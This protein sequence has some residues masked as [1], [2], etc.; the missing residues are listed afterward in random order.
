MEP[1]DFCVACGGCCRWYKIIVV[2]EEDVERLARHLALSP[3]ETNDK[4]VEVY[5]LKEV[6]VPEVHD[7][8]D[9]GDRDDIERY[10]NEQ[11]YVGTPSLK[12]VR[13]R[14]CVF[15][16]DEGLCSVHEARPDVCRDWPSTFEYARNEGC[17]IGYAS[18][19]DLCVR[20]GECC[21]WG[22]LVQIDD[23]DMYALAKGLRKS[24]RDLLEDGV[25]VLP[26]FGMVLRH[27]QGEDGPECVFLDGDLCGV[28]EF[29][30]RQCRENPR[31]FHDAAANG[32]P[33]GRLETEVAQS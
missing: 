17:P 6:L 10:L 11:G 7:A 15:L 14:G 28:E 21:R 20:C 26:A 2:T 16:T 23:A 27:K 33:V 32:C 12:S 4:Y 8:I 13:G 3:E 22:G 30:P 9:Q 1:S 5:S 31:S 24:V 19:S 29:K 25:E 18:P